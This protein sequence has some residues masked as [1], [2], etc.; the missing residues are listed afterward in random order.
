[1][2]IDKLSEVKSRYNLDVPLEDEKSIPIEG[3]FHY[4]CRGIKGIKVDKLKVTEYGIKDD[5]VFVVINK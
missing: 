1:V 3:L 5:R 2:K 4:P